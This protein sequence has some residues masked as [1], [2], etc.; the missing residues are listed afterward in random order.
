MIGSSSIV[1]IAAALLKAQKAMGNATK[2]AKNPFFKST[3]ADLNSIREAAIP[4]LNTNGVSVLQPTCVIDGKNYVETVLLHESGEWVSSLTDIVNGKGDA[5]GEGSGIS[6]ARRYGL[7]SLLNIGAVDDDGEAAQGRQN[8][9]SAEKQIAG[10]STKDVP[11][12]TPSGV[13]AMAGGE[14]VSSV[15]HPI[16]DRIFSAYILLE[17][18]GKVTKDSFKKIYLG[19][20]GLKDRSVADMVTIYEQM[21]KDFPHINGGMK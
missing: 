2:G 12:K 15:N 3:Y 1:K 13:S 8:V 19:G 11:A 21:K 20:T 6:Y 10:K 7:Q 5:Q 16:K 18:Q 4:A 14:S 17:T 9:H